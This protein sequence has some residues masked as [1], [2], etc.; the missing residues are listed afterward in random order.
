MKV[1]SKEE[2]SKEVIK[3]FRQ[4][5]V[6]LNPSS[7]MIGLTLVLTKHCLHRLLVFIGF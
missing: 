4:E 6:F 5:V 7:I 3:S 1:F 2:Y